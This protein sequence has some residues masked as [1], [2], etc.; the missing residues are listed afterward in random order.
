MSLKQP[1]FNEKYC[2]G[3]CGFLNIERNSCELFETEDGFNVELELDFD[4]SI[5]S[6]A[7][8][9]YF[10]CPEC[11]AAFGPGDQLRVVKVEGNYK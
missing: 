5:N 3:E 10:R 9:E 4:R 11:L 1:I 8:F 7:A 2:S 6:Y